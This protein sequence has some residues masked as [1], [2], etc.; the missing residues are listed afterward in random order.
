VLPVVTVSGTVWGDIDNSANDTFTNINTGAETGTNAGNSLQALLVNVGGNVIATTPVNPDGTYSFSGLVGNQS[1]VTIRLTISAGLV[2][3]AAPSAGVPTGWVNTSPLTTAAFNIGSSNLTGQDFGIQQLPVAAATDPASQVN[4][5]GTTLVTV[6]STHFTGSDPD[7][8]IATFKFTSFPTNATSITINGTNYTSGTFPSGGVTV[9]ATSG[10]LPANV[11][12]IDPLDGA[13]TAAIPF[14]VIDNA[15]K[16]STTSAAVQVA[17]TAAPPDVTLVKSCPS[18]ADCLTASQSPGTELTYQINFT[19][20]GGSAAQQLVLV[21]AV[22]DY[23]DFKV[24]SVT[25]NLGTTGLVMTVEYSN[26]YNSASPGTATWTYTPS[27][28]GGG[29]AS[30]YDRNVRAI[31]WRVTAGTL[32]YLAPN[33]TGNFGFTVKIR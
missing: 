25:T 1:N 28:G 17:F 21:D 13:V 8:T 16:E 3:A 5:G 26:D 6:P 12:S 29:A 10:A 27:S 23:T 22:P 2:G 18:P 7:G 33:N 24:S 19:N 31:R 30:G 4:P 11:V 20:V 9:A 15:G 14:I 32:S